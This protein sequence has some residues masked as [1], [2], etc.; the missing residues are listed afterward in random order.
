MRPLAFT[1]LVTAATFALLSASTAVTQDAATFENVRLLTNVTSKSEMRAIMKEQAKALGVKCTHCHVKGK[2]GAED[3]PEKEAA[4]E[5]MTM[6]A[7][8]NERFFPDAAEPA[9][10][11]W[12]CHRGAT[13]PE[14]VRPP[15]A[16]DAAG[17]DAAAAGGGTQ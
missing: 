15:S 13:E 11:C 3:K 16:D 12:T 17:P 14:S 7:E 1:C 6:V 9:V 5:M 10:T 8:L 2:F 4:R